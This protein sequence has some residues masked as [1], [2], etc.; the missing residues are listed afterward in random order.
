MITAVL[1][2]MDIKI[3]GAVLVLKETTQSGFSS[4]VQTKLHSEAHDELYLNKFNN[5]YLCSITC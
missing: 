3:K 1:G 5:V 4:T 2:T